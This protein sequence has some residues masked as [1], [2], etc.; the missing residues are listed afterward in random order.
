MNNPV[1][2]PW[3]AAYVSAFME[4]NPSKASEKLD[5]ALRA[6]KDRMREPVERNSDEFQAIQDATAGIG[7][8][9]AGIGGKPV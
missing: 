7:V 2:Y 8:L 3:Q 1:T 4:L 9:R 5:V 6:I